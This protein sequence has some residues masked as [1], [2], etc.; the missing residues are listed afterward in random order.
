MIGYADPTLK[1]INHATHGFD[2]LDG[3]TFEVTRSDSNIVYEINGKPA[4]SILTKTLGVPE[5]LTSMELLT[6]SG[7]AREIPERL[8]EENESKYLLFVSIGKNADNSLI[9]SIACPEGMKFWLTKR[10]EKMMFEGVDRMVKKIVDELRGSKPV[11]VFHADC[12][13]RGRFSLDRILKDEII[14]HM[15]SPICGR[16]DIPW[17][18]LYSAGEFLMLGGEA[19]FQQ[20]SSSLFVIYR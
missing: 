17:L 8:K 6:I 1:F 12:V 19:W 20:I 14:N 7:F 15:Q 11:A 16:E 13:L 4:W 2:V 5:T 10:D 18:G 3:M 9:M